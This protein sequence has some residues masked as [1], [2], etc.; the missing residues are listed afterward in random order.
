MNIMAVFFG[1]LYLFLG[2]RGFIHLFRNKNNNLSKTILIK[3][4]LLIILFFLIGFLCIISNSDKFIIIGCIIPLI[5]FFF[6][7]I[8][9]RKN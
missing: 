6:N 2:L 1:I 3:N 9:N 4:V 5:I 8:T 7:M